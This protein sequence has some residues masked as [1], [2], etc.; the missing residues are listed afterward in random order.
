MSL[1]YCAYS[2]LKVMASNVAPP[3]E[4]NDDESKVRQPLSPMYFVR[5]EELDRKSTRLNSSHMSESRMP[6]SA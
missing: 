3:Q 5:S 6:S 4:E 2:F 1:T